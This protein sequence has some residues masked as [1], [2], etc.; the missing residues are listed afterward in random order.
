MATLCAINYHIALTSRDI[1][2]LNN[3]F[4]SLYLMGLQVKMVKFSCYGE[5]PGKSASSGLVAV[6]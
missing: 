4:R 5:K 2:C 6:N 1:A 3:M